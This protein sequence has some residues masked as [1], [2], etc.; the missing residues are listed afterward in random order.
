GAFLAALALADLWRIHWPAML[1]SDWSS[2]QASA[3]PAEIGASPAAVFH[4]Q[5]ADHG[6]RPWNPKFAL[7]EDLRAFERGVWAD[8]GGN[9]AL[10]YGIRFVAEASGIRRRRAAALYRE[11]ERLPID[12]AVRLLRSLGV[13]FLI[14]EV[15]LTSPGL[16][17]LREGGSGR[18]WIYR[19][20]GAAPRTYLA[21]RLRPVADA[22]SAFRELAAP[23][24]RPG[25]EA[26][27]EGDCPPS[28]DCGNASSVG[29]SAPGSASITRDEPERIE[30]DASLV[31][32][33]LLVIG[34]SWDADWVAEV[35][36]RRAPIVPANGIVRGVPLGAGEHRV[37]L[38]YAPRSF[39]LG[40][41]ISFA[42]I[43]LAVIVALTAILRLMN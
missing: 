1:F 30:I 39:R 3:P 11:L 28:L 23:A 18:A 32:P 26:M 41:V 31:H 35:D 22:S 8:L 7:G 5:R 12:G 42:G 20:E 10:A 33:A 16:E 13:G 27:V 37:V 21:S 43:A 29:S 9:V 36:G 14:G 6:L 4:Y 19:L 17:R 24:F 38:R 2:L 15:A 25:E 40:L 34:D